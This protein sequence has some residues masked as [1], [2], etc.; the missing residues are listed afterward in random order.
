MAT[1]KQSTSL[2][3]ETQR[4]YSYWQALIL[5]FFSSLLYWDVYKRWKGFG[6]LYLLFM[7]CIFTIPYGVKNII[8][9]RQFFNK[10]IIDPFDR[11]P[12]ISYVSGELKFDK[13]MPYFIK[14]EKGE[15]ETIIDNTGHIKKFDQKK[16]PALRFL[17]I[18]SN[19]FYT[20]PEASDYFT[21][22]KDRK[23]FKVREIKV[24]KDISFV[25][26]GDLFIK[27]FQIKNLKKITL[28]G[29]YPVVA[30]SFFLV[31]VVFLLP[32]AMM[33]QLV[34]QV[35]FKVQLYYKQ[36]CRL[37]CMATT[38]AFFVLQI[39]AVCHYY[40]KYIGIVWLGLLSMYFSFAVIILKRN[41]RS[42]ARL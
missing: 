9:T 16:Y 31:W 38:P 11:I 26:N 29:I 4:L 40:E 42:I 10:T 24:P 30:S 36:S 3:Q 20:M 28:G 39:M 35:I 41:L 19:A 23:P 21:E 27:D 17:F 13:K 37:L 22:P 18:N 5:S 12:D 34:S 15:V 7:V 25:F 6:F 14:N 32:L 1:K 2:Q 8:E 33:G